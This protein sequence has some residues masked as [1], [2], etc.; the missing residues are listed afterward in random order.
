MLFRSVKAANYLY[1]GMSSDSVQFTIAKV[2]AETFQLCAYLCEK[3]VQIDRVNR[4]IYS[5]SKKLFS[6]VCWCGQQVRYLDNVGY[7]IINDTDRQRFNL[8]ISQV[9]DQVNLMN[10]IEGVDCW[11]LACQLEGD[12]YSVSIRSF[13]IPI[14]QI[15]VKY[16]GGGHSLACGIP[17]VTY[18]QLGQLIK[19][20]AA[21]ARC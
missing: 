20:T 16:G 3:N 14:D 5:K 18:A 13:N 10:N 4:L 12:D 15:A 19:D 7:V 17:H 9:K 21:Q 11:I 1:A 2:K 6:F 8:T